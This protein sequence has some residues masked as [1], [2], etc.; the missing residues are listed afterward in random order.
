MRPWGQ[1][2]LPADLVNFSVCTC[3]NFLQ[4]GGGEGDA[5]QRTEAVGGRF[6]KF[7]S[8]YNVKIS[9]SAGA[10]KV[11]RPWGQRQ[12][13]GRP[14]S[15]GQKWRASL[16]ITSVLEVNGQIMVLSA[17]HCKKKV[18]DLPVPSRDVT[19][20]TLPGREYLNYFQPGRGC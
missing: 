12:L 6:S 17:L 9:Y 5:S 13:P 15:A 3:Q 1:R 11:M 14:P 2:Q 8:V 7:Y 20:Q 4:C 19:Y 16:D 18:N 10:G